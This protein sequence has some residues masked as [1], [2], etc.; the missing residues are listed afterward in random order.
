ML[1]LK[2]VGRIVLVIVLLGLAKVFSWAR[3]ICPDWRGQMSVEVTLSTVFL[4]LAVVFFAI[5][6]WLLLVA[7]RDFRKGRLRRAVVARIRRNQARTMEVL[8]L[9]PPR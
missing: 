5:S 2:L 9:H 1:W 3:S 8:R 7:C 4:F 6:I